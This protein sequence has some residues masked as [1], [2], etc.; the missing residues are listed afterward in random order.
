MK[1]GTMKMWMIGG[2]IL[3]TGFVG[4]VLLIALRPDP[5]KIEPEH[6][7]PLVLAVKAERGSGPLMIRGNGSVQPVREIDLA[8]EVSGKVVTVSDAF[9]TGGAFHTGESLLRID[10]SDYINAVAMAEAEVTQWKYNVLTAEEEVLLA[11]E[12]WERLKGRSDVSDLPDSTDL[13]VLVL[14]EP[15]LA[16]AKAN[17]QSAE[18]RLADARTRLERTH[19]RAPFNGIVRAKNV[20]LG[21]FVAPGQIVGRIYSTDAV[22]IKVPLSSES[23]SLIEGIWRRNGSGRP[24]P[25]AAKVIT[26]VGG[27]T[28]EYLGYIHRVEGAIDASTRTIS[29][30][31]RVENAYET[32]N[33]HP[34]LFVGTFATVELEGITPEDYFSIPRSGLREG[35]V[36]W[37]VEDGRLSIQPVEIL[38]EA[39]DIA[40]VR[41]DFKGEPMVITSALALV[42]D[43][44]EVRVAE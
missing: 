37:I 9:V 11:K 8:S 4:M 34:P 10:P 27:K 33:E 41:G 16:A 24:T 2:G 14:K 7:A 40:F 22:E 13:G 1:K 12:E 26:T 25:A 17:L 30:V 43:G 36:V 39:N 32:E 35:D 44:M 42:I 18:A 3:A 20:D 5:P 28:F 21:Q 31:V 38:Q 6:T 15:Q 23:A 29:V 19:V